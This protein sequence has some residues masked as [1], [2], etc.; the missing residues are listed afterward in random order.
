VEVARLIEAGLLEPEIGAKLFPVHNLRSVERY[1][2]TY[3]NVLKL[4]EHGLPP[5]EIA[6]ILKL[7]NRL[8][9]TYIDIVR[10]HHPQT[11]VANPHLQPEAPS[12]GSEST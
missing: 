5:S 4:I 11:I 9:Q 1:A 10:E 12:S 2:Q 6:A 8:M 3:K 7:S